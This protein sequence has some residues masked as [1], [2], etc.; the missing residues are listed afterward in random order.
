[1]SSGVSLLKMIL[2]QL[3]S[4]D[5]LQHDD[6]HAAFAVVEYLC[7]IENK[8]LPYL[9]WNACSE[10]A[11]DV[12]QDN[13]RSNG[14]CGSNTTLPK[15]Q[16]KMLREFMRFKQTVEG[17]QERN[18]QDLAKSDESK[19]L[20][21]LVLFKFIR[22]MLRVEEIEKLSDGDRARLLL[23]LLSFV[24]LALGVGGSALQS[25]C[26]FGNS[27][28]GPKASETSAKTKISSLHPSC[29]KSNTAVLF[30]HDDLPLVHFKPPHNFTLN[31]IF[32]DGLIK[33][34]SSANDCVKN[35]TSAKEYLCQ[36]E[37]HNP[38]HVYSISPV[39]FLGSCRH[40]F[41]ESYGHL[42]ER[43]ENISDAKL[44]ETLQ[45]FLNGLHETHSIVNDFVQ[46]LQTHNMQ[47]AQM[48]E[49]ALMKIEEKSSTAGGLK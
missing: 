46:I 1:M 42:Q 21:L 32:M 27:S 15:D 43:L 8:Y 9:I 45:S 24:S 31:P 23:V 2:N 10:S 36:T 5:V 14:A 44:K 49:R 12:T 40:I 48:F 30:T 3:N 29:K 41:I 4:I 25:Q 22:Q 47:P 6:L 11:A 33:V 13:V 34:V 37:P 19:Q 18:L 35:F 39:L 26:L 17:N 16:R 28:S 38:Q 20:C 7:L